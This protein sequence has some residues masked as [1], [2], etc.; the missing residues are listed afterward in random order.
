MLLEAG[1]GW[2]RS[3]RYGHRPTC[4]SSRIL[5]GQEVGRRAVADRLLAARYRPAPGPYVDATG[6][7]RRVQALMAVGHTVIV[8]G[9]ESGVDHSVIHDILNGCLTV[10]G[11]TADRIAAAYDWL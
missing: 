5:A 3:T 10:R 11:I 9:N 8:I 6:T 4:T 7:R 2:T 1:M